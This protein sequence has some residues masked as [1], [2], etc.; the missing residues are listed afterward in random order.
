MGSDSGNGQRATVGL[1]ATLRNTPAPQLWILFPMRLDLAVLGPR[2]ARNRPLPTVKEPGLPCWPLSAPDVWRA[3]V[4]KAARG[5]QRTS[6]RWC[7]AG[8]AGGSELA[9]RQRGL[10]AGVAMIALLL[11]IE[12]AAEVVAEG[13]ERTLSIYNIHTKET[14]TAV[15]KRN[16][17]F[18]EDGLKQLSHVMRDHRRNEE[19]RMDP[20]LI[21]LLWEIHRELGSKEPIHLVSGYRSHATNELLRRTVGGQASQSRHIL[22][23][24]ADVHFPDVPLKLIRYSALIH[25]RGGVGYYP[26][27]ALPFVHIDTDR[28][29]SWPRLPRYELAL[30][31]PSGST[32]HAAADGGPLTG[33]DVRLART[34]HGELAQQIAQFQTLRADGINP[35]ALASARGPSTAGRPSGSERVTALPRPVD[36]PMPTL[37]ELPKPVAPREIAARLPRLEASVLTPSQG[38]RARLA[39][40]AGLAS[41]MPQLVSGPV[42]AHRPEK[43]R[44]PSLTGNAQPLPPGAIAS[45][46]P[47]QPERQVASLG[48][49][50]LPEAGPSTLT[51]AGR[52]GW[53]AW[54]PAP[55]YDEE[56]PEEL[57][58]RPF[59]IVPYLTDSPTQPLMSELVAH[60]VARTLDMLDQPEGGSALHFGPA[61]Q[62]AESLWALTFKRKAVATGNAREVE[63]PASNGLKSRAVRTTQR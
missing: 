33:D 16:G 26:T 53:G 30:L 27:S 12:P 48:P 4:S 52:F 19:T 14:V 49:T 50:A 55:A 54:V 5:P 51:D 11:A 18:V 40:L 31:F 23:K 61:P 29:R 41:T 42:L 39:E 21:D 45:L 46:K 25:E 20:E 9:V 7:A 6:G 24:A 36:T 13:G 34:Q 2:R 43:A 10:W 35:V 57:S 15:F 38:D 8:L 28:V 17:R 1:A 47:D 58:Y 60:D 37:V 22:G 63:P 62:I 32:Q 59:P 44:L 56:H 3:A